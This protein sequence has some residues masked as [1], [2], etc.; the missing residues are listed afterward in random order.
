MQLILE[1]YPDY[2]R[3]VARH[4][5]L[6]AVAPFRFAVTAALFRQANL[7]VILMISHD[8]GGGV[9]RHIDTL[10]ERIGDS[11]HVLL[12]E[13]TDRGACLS[14]PSLPHHPTL[15]LPAER[16]DDLVLL[17]R[18]MNVSRVHIHHLL[19][20]DMDIR[21]LIHRLGLPF[22]VTVHDYYAHLSADKP[23]APAGQSSIAANRTSPP[24][25]PASPHGRRTAPATS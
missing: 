9:R 8:L 4:V 15:T 7:P 1:R 3:D 11:A 17:L 5:S 23:A 25:T 10:V 13:A 12:L 14:V 19:G 16:I 18:S 22:D 6:D 2:S 24:A 21:A 20:M